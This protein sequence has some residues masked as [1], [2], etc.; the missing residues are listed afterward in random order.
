[1]PN[2]WLAAMRIRM[3]RGGHLHGRVLLLAVAAAV[4]VPVQPVLAQRDSSRARARVISTNME[5]VDR[6]ARSAEAI[7]RQQVELVRLL[8]SEQERIEAIRDEA[9]RQRLAAFTEGLTARLAQ[10]ESEL[11]LLRRRIE[12]ACRRTPRAEGWVGL[13]VNSPFRV[14]QLSN[15]RIAHQYMGEPVVESVDP[16]SPA[17]RAG[18]RSGDVLVSIAGRDVRESGVPMAEVLLPDRAVPFVVRRGDDRE[19]TIV[20]RVEQRPQSLDRAPCPWIDAAIASALAPTPAQAYFRREQPRLSVGTV[21]SSARATVWQ[22]T[23][24]DSQPPASGSFRYYASPMV[25][26]F[27]TGTNTVAGLQMHALNEELGEYY[28]TSRG[29]LVL[30]VL[31]GTLG[32][33]AGIRGGDVLLTADEVELRSPRT[34]EVVMNRSRSQEVELRILRAKERKTVVLRW[35]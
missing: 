6:L 7:R 3:G 11:T 8:M 30:E 14:I 15:G 28:G 17:D 24:P 26:F 16:G 19:V 31:P 1:M 27:S 33:R 9:E 18:I 25:S 10:T 13:A 35:D 21:R 34:L 5:Q 12:E 32:H 2:Q 4:A 29:L 20:V 23:E 22:R